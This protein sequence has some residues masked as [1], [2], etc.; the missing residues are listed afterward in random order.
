MSR[1]SLFLII[2]FVSSGYVVSA[3]TVF[4][5]GPQLEKVLCKNWV[6][7]ADSQ[8]FQFLGDST[9]YITVGSY[10]YFGRWDFEPKTQT[11]LLD[12][13]EDHLMDENFHVITLNDNEFVCSIRAKCGGPTA[14]QTL[15]PIVSK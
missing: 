9:F 4:T 11:L 6:C 15:L 12:Y 5:T 7:Q 8:T 14:K 10:K 13:A 2:A 1:L 3:Q